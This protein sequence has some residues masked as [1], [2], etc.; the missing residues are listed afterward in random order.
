M[1]MLKFLTDYYWICLEE[2]LSIFLESVYRYLSPKV[3]SQFSSLF[4]S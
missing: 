4:L 3:G 1:V 2:L